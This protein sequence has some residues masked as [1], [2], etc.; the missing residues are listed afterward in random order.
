MEP[1][2]RYQ[3]NSKTDALASLLVDNLRALRSASAVGLEG[4]RN[5]LEP[6]V[7]R[8]GSIRMP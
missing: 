1:D 7:T 2:S 3:I 6:G 5:D 8:K 4:A